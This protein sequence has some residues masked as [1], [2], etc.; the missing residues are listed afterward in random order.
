MASISP[1]AEE[2]LMQIWTK[3]VYEE[4]GQQ[5]GMRV[6]VDRIWPRGVS[7][8]EALIDHWLKDIAPS[9]ELRKWFNHDPQKWVEFKKKYFL[10]LKGKDEELEELLRMAHKG[11]VTLVYGAKDQEHNNAVALKEYLEEQA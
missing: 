6:L 4:P 5:D 9:T 3:R 1:R 7:K 11:R 2:H 8:D 10:E